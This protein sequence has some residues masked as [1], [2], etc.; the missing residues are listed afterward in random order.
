MNK[1]KHL[2][3]FAILLDCTRDAGC[4]ENTT[5]ILRY[6]DTETGF[7]EE[8][9]F[10]FIA[11]QEITAATLTD[12]ILRE[13]QSLGLNI[14]DCHGQGY[15]SGANIAG[16]NL[17]VKRKILA[18]SPRAFFAACD[19]HNWNMLSGDAA[20]SSRMAVSFFGLIQRIY[21]LCSRS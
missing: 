5:V 11:V 21:T 9:S 3:H 15:D 10:G 1:I 20:K 18:I 14:N 13:L 4:V 19:C 12:T 7:I 17:C 8:H 2:K 16:V 6:F